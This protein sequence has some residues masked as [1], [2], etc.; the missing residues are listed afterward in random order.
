MKVRHAS[1][2]ATLVYS[3]IALVYVGLVAAAALA[4]SAAWAAEVSPTMSV[5]AKFQV[6]DTNHDGFVSKDEV[7]RYRGYGKAFDEAD[8]NRDGKLNAEEFVKSE[9]IY[10]RMQAA[11]YVDD[12]VITAKVKTA[13]VRA[14]KSLDVKVETQRGHV[15]LS[16]FVADQAQRDKA[17]QVAA[18]VGGVVKVEDGLALK[19]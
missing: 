1:I 8:Q 5:E 11:A 3:G 6:L 18:S 12:S 13:L 15:L 2:T 7:K 9:A 10:Q 14:M 17:L 19:P 4:T 16:G